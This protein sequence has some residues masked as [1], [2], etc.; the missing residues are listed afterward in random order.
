MTIRII[1]A[2]RMFIRIS[3]STRCWFS[4][5]EPVRGLPEYEWSAMFVF[6]SLKALPHSYSTSVPQRTPFVS[7]KPQ[8]VCTSPTVLGAPASRPG[9]RNWLRLSVQ[10]LYIKY[11]M[12]LYLYS[13]FIGLQKRSFFLVNAYF[14]I[15]I[16]VCIIFF[17]KIHKLELIRVPRCRLETDNLFPF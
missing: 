1:D 17:S 14:V 3:S 15:A 2:M 5:L 16:F 4:S 10:T 9:K 8:F 6:P 12:N 11:L 7:L 13:L